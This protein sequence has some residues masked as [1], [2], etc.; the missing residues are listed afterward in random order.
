MSGQS[1]SGSLQWYGQFSVAGQR[2]L[3]RG[4]GPAPRGVSPHG[5]SR[6]AVLDPA[7]CGGRRAQSVTR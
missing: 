5:T 3:V 4:R 1:Y 7:I 6:M 2:L